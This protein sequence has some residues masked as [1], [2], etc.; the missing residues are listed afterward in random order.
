MAANPLLYRNL[1]T[2][3]GYF[4]NRDPRFDESLSRPTF[5][6]S[7]FNEIQSELAKRFPN[8]AYK[9][10]LIA[11]FDPQ[12]FKGFLEEVTSDPGFLQEF[13]DKLEQAVW[14]ND[15]SSLE[16]ESGE[17]AAGPQAG[18]PSGEVPVNPEQIPDIAQKGSSS[19]FP[20][21]PSGSFSTFSSRPI[22]RQYP[23][24]SGKEGGFGEGTAATSKTV[25]PKR[26]R[27]LGAD[28]RPIGSS[29][30]SQI[31]GPDG[32]P[33]RQVQ[34]SRLAGPDGQ[35]LGR[36]IPRYP[37]A[38][39]SNVTKNMGSQIG[40]GAHKLTTRAPGFIRGF[41]PEGIGGI[42]G[43]GGA[44]KGSFLNNFSRGRG[45]FGIPN[46]FG[47][48]G[49]RRGGFPGGSRFGNGGRNLLRSGGKKW[50]LWLLLLLLLGGM[51]F[52][53]F[54]PGQDNEKLTVKIEKKAPTQVDNG[55]IINYTINV[56]N[57]ASSSAEIQVTD[58]LPS[59]VEFVD[60]NPKPD[61][62]GNPLVWFLKNVG[63]NQIKAIT[64]SVKPTISDAW[65]QNNVEAI[66]LST[67]GGGVSPGGGEAPT[68]D[69][70][71][72]YLLNNP[73]GN[74]GDPTCNFM[75]DD[76]FNLIKQ[77]DP[78]NAIEWFNGIVPCESSYNPN[79]Y[80]FDS[81]SGFGGYGL[82]QMNPAGK[83]TGQFDRGDVD[84][85][86]QT[87]NAINHNKYIISLGG[88]WSYWACAYKFPD[89]KPISR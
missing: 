78:E 67:S 12:K 64:L 51:F 82:Y 69:N 40:I 33:I 6:G 42:F 56:T 27:L 44:G 77:N 36:P 68:Q 54:G 23:F 17:E 30:G 41:L 71:G 8:Y 47:G 85:R 73:L 76:L 81:T 50:L 10:D 29:G 87:S 15:W 22:V 24:R 2:L 66:N 61:K 26:T 38:G 88:K 48:G 70:C 35:L 4:T 49:G 53:L 11:P 13:Y 60:A 43:R 28:G 21:I 16:P 55:Q 63:G 89:Y 62:I 52:S 3:L 14:T 31:L 32:K 1:Y 79:A 72:K 84:W 19:A 39:L 58:A 34:I 57:L 25:A 74:F 86:F 59:G 46:F 18:Q 80:N 45:G 5:N 20:S 75:K 7:P 37:A 65:I 9:L 83:G